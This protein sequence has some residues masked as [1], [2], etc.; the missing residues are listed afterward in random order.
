MPEGMAATSAASGSAI[1]PARA[2]AWRISSTCWR[3]VSGS[4]GGRQAATCTS[5]ARWL[6]M[7]RELG[8]SSIA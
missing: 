7:V 8:T 6:R 1:A 4:G 3:T 5:G 2:A